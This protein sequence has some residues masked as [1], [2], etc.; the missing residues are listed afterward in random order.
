MNVLAPELARIKASGKSKEEQARETFELYKKHNANPFSGCLIQIPI[1]IIIISLYYIVA[2]G[3]EFAPGNLYS[4][5]RP[6]EELN[7]HF[8][9]LIDIGKKSF[10]LAALAGLSQYF[11]ALYMPMPAPSAEA[12]G[13]FGQSFQKSMALQA[14][15]FFPILIFFILYTN[16]LGPYGSGALAIY[17]ITN[18]IFTIG[19]QIYANRKNPKLN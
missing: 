5:V 17:W 15:Y 11:Q 6:P 18:N 2:Q 8:L 16:I 9:G 19:Q 14:K 4:F 3:L 12:G 7:M 13:T 10:I 1:I